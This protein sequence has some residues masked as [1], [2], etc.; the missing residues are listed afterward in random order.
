MEQHMGVGLLLPS[1]A[2]GRWMAMSATMPLADELVPDEGADQLDLLVLGQLP[3]EGDFDL[4]G[5]LGVHPR[6]RPLDHVP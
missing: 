2:E 1:E 6:L 3:R 4:A 5:E